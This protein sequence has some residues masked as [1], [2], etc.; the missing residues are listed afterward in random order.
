MNKSAFVRARI[1]PE[2]KMF[3]EAILNELGINPSQAITMLY[4]QIA[5]EQ[6]WPFELKVPNEETRRILQETDEGIGLKKC[7]NVDD[8]FKKLGI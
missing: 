2:L 1:E 6:G 4:K 3:A 7:K 8:L 5:R